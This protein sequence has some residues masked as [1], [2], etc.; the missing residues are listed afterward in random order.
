MAGTFVIQ[1]EAEAVVI[2]TGAETTLARISTWL[3]Q[4]NGHPAR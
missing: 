2:A 4:P 3:E 1:G